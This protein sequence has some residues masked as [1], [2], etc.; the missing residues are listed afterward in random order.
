MRSGG[1]IWE[2]LWWLPCVKNLPVSI[3]QGVPRP[4]W[5]D[6]LSAEAPAY[7]GMTM[8]LAGMTEC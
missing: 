4:F 6:V 1:A 3:L 5:M 7:A 2:R 8:V